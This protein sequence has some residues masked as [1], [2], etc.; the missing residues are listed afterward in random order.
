MTLTGVIFKG[1]KSKAQLRGIVVK[2]KSVNPSFICFQISTFAL[3]L[4]LW[5]AQL[6][7]LFCRCWSFVEKNC[8][9]AV[10]PENRKL[11]VALNMKDILCGKKTF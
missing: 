7:L 11:N 6:T 3:L 10:Q 2:K 5:V 4:Y 9:V 8:F 1:R